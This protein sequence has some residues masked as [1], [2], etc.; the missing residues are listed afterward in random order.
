MVNLKSISRH[1]L[2]VGGVLLVCGLAGA[3]LGRISMTNSLDALQLSEMQ[4]TI[5]AEPAFVLPPAAPEYDKAE[6]LASIPDTGESRIWEATVRQAMPP[7]KEPL[8]PPGWRIVGV[9]TIGNEKNALLLFDKQPATEVRKIGDKLPGGAKIIDI[10]PDHL[11]IS[12]NGQIMKLNL[13][14]Q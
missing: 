7:R 8:T 1:H 14:K 9:T 5:V 6:E 13:R 12:L 11:Q 2:I 10:L 4:K 3:I